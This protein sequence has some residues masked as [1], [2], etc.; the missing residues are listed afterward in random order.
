MDKLKSKLTVT[1]LLE[2]RQKPLLV[3]DGECAF[4]SKLAIKWNEKTGEQID[5]TPYSEIADNFQQIPIEEFNKEIKLIYPEGRV[6]SGAEAAFKVLEY[7]KSPLRALSWL[8]NQTRAFDPIWKWAYRTV[9]RNRHRIIY[10]IRA[11]SRKN[12]S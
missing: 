5:F 3:F 6:Y 1:R 7:S 4:C 8:Y 10:T 11:L 2:A 12:R 9:A